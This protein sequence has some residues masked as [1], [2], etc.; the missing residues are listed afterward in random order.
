MVAGHTAIQEIDSESARA[1]AQ[2]RREGVQSECLFRVVVVVLLVAISP[3]SPAS[4]DRVVLR[5]PLSRLP[6]T[7]SAQAGEAEDPLAAQVP[8]GHPG[9]R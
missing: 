5:P 1:A 6:A 4:S 2:P 3:S 7:A 9:Q 8:A